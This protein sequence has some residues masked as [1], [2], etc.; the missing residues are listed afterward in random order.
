MC[1]DSPRTISMTN[2]TCIR[3]GTANLVT[4]E[5]CRICGAELGPLPAPADA[6][7]P[8]SR[9]YVTTIPPFTSPGDA[10]G[11]TFRLFTRNFWL[12]TKI[13]FVIVA[14]F[15]VFSVLSSRQL[16]MDWQ[17]GFGLFVLR[18]MCNVLVAPALFYALLKVMETG[19]APGVNEAYRWGVSKIPKLA[20]A[21]IVSWILTALGF[22]LLI[23]P[24][25]ILSMAFIL[26]SPVAI[27]EKGSPIDA[28]RRSWRLTDGHRWNI[29]AASIV[30][31]LA[32]GAVGLVISGGLSLFV[33]SSG[34]WPLAVVGQIVT[35]ILG[36]ASTV[37]A[38]V[39]YLGILRTL[40]SDASVIE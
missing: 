12:I 4:D 7:T 39:L 9:V 22:V 21:A 23:I 17:L 18:L 10:I 11:P 33:F 15:E 40:E 24:G 8:S 29:F 28:L 1:C 14:P 20:I 30:V 27:F 26:V 31:G 25:L 3:C 13:V 6:E 19:S 32:V 35:S 36:E 16:T 34:F 37:L 5:V 38:L 2:V